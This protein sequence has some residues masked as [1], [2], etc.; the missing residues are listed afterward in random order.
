MKDKK[1]LIIGET[2]IDEFV[3]GECY[4][5]NPEAP[6][7][8]FT[9]K[10]I[11]RNSGMAG[12]VLDNLN[13]IGL[14][15]D[16]ITNQERIVKT[17]YVDKVSNYI[18]LRVDNDNY[19]EPL[20]R[21]TISKID[22]NKYNAIVISDYD[23]GLLTNDYL[24]RI[25]IMASSYNIPTFMD[26]KKSIGGWASDCTFI[27]INEKEYSNPKHIEILKSTIFKDNLI[28]TLGSNGCMYKEEIYPTKKVSVRDVV[29]AGDTFLC[30]LVYG[31]LKN[32]EI[33]EGIKIANLL[34]SDVVSKTGVSLPN[35][36]LTL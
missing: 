31:Y 34:A 16:I 3:Y 15:N 19:I 14:N 35:K 33:K 7:P 20:N 24:E 25:F 13:H 22:F 4:R 27:K 21:N 2:C 8:V 17:R 28:V 5:L 32:K 36:E 30:G 12:N 9:P 23:K 10:E 6:T 18:L 29:G 11:K 26:T 1:V